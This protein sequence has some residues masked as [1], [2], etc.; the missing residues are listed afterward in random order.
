MSDPRLFTS[1][2]IP[3]PILVP[4]A[5]PPR[6]V[7]GTRLSTP[8]GPRAVEMLAV[9]DT[10]TTRSGPKRIARLGEMRK[11]RA[12]WTFDRSVWPVRVP[13]GSLGNSRPMR[14]SPDQRVLL[15]G[16]TLARICGVPEVSVAVRDLV[17]LRGIIV[18][19]PLADL[20]YH[21]LSFGIPAIVEA[22]GVPCEVEAS[23]AAAVAHDLVRKAYQ[24]M[25]AVGEP[26]MKP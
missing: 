13:V 11:S 7:P 19:R 22:E 6:F 14:L 3:I 21:G 4:S 15:S 23:D 10:V 17:G 24:A 12:E 2:A 16:E 5:I 1:D 25:H 8:D 26:E 9:G 18:E 20:R